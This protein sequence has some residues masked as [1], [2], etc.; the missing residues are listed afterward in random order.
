MS[1]DKNRFG[2]QKNIQKKSLR[3][4]TDNRD[5]SK[6]E[7]CKQSVICPGDPIFQHVLLLQDNTGMQYRKDR[8]RYARYHIV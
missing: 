3:K 7:N 2:E 6:P 1:P 4:A 5:P 8:L